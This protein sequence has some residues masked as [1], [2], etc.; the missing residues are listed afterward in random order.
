MIL[1]TYIHSNL[2][3]KLLEYKWNRQL[4]NEYKKF[5]FWSFSNCYMSKRT[6]I[7]KKP[8][9][10]VIQSHEPSPNDYIL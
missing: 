2:T 6:N 10:Y 8:Y 1:H 5:W 9:L 4:L 7:L 3:V